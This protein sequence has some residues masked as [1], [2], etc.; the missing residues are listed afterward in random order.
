[1]KTICNLGLATMLALC[2]MLAAN[3]RLDAK[4]EH[5]PS[6]QSKQSQVAS[7]EEHHEPDPFSKSLD[8]AIW[9]M[10]V[11]LLLV[12][13]LKK[14]AWGP[15]LE[16]L[17]RREE[18]IAHALTEAALAKEEASK[19]R[20]E[21]SAE[22]AK[23]HDQ[24]REIMEE[25]RRDAQATADAIVSKGKAEIQTERD[26]LR[27]EME[28]ARDQALQELWAQSA[29]LATLISTKALRRNIGADDHRRLVQDA[30]G[31]LGSAGA[32]KYRERVGA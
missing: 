30:I 24:V 27:R 13:V 4:E 23:A 14:Y 15:I 22:L 21:L 32:S 25:A 31:E 19:L 28:T 6:G 10:V 20:R 16:G 7:K 1:M 17:K 9:S 26:R 18:G 29:E 8:L 2:T 3:S 5:P 11:F 12:L